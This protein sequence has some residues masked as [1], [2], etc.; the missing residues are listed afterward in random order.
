MAYQAERLKNQGMSAG[1][2]GASSNAL[3]ER[4]RAYP[5][6]WREFLHEVRLEMRQVTWPSRHEVVV[7]T[8]VVI[9]AVAFFGVFF[10]GVDSTV[11]FLFQRLFALFQH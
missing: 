2:S 4:L 11:G 8:F 10:F 7:T 1:A 5:R 9:V 3:W 6:R